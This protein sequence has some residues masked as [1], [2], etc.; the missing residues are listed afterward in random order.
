[1]PKFDT[2]IA[3]ARPSP[4]IRSNARQVSTYLSSVGIGQWI[5]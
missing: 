3:F 4:W 5:R 1:M 2:P